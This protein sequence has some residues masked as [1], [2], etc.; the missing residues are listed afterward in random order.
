MY[1]ARRVKVEKAV[2]TVNSISADVTATQEKIVDLERQRQALMAGCDAESKEGDKSLADQ[3]IMH[4]NV[5][6]VFVRT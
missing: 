1:N 6:C 5:Y 2:G 4:I 3:V